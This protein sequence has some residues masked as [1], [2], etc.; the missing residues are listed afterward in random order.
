MRFVIEC[1]RTEDMLMHAAKRPR[2]VL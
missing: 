2:Q 1:S